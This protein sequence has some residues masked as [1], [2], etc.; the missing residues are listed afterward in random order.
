MTEIYDKR[1]AIRNA[2]FLYGRMLVTMLLNLLT[3]RLVLQNL[4]VADMAIYAVVGSV[5]S[6]V[7]FLGGSIGGAVQRFITYEL[8]KKD[9]NVNIVFNS[10]LNS[11]FIVIFLF[12]VLLETLGVWLLDTK[13]NIPTESITAAHWAFHFCVITFIVDTFCIPYDSIIV[14]HEKMNVFAGVTILK[15]LLTCV[16][17]FLISFFD[18][19]LLV[20]SL[21]LMAVSLFIRVLYQIYCRNRFSSEIK[22]QLNIDKDIIK[23]IARYFGVTSFGSVLYVSSH[24][25]IVWVLNILMGVSLNAVFNIANQLKNTIL[26]FSMNINR[27]ISPQ[28]TK[29]YANGMMHE[30][31]NLVNIGMRLNAFMMLLILFPFIFYA[32]TFMQLWLKDVPEY[33]VFF[34]QLIAFS[35]FFDCLMQSIGSAVFATG[36]I[37]AFLLVTRS[38]YLLVLPLMYFTY[39]FTLSPKSLICSVVLMDLLAMFIQMIIVVK[40]K[41][42]DLRDGIVIPMMRIGCVSI[43]SAIICASLRA[44]LPHDVIGLILLC[45]LHTITILPFM[46]IIGATSGEKAKIKQKMKSFHWIAQSNENPFHNK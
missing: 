31:K 37:K 13:L 41:I 2:A 17:A 33:T 45:L 24:Q 4:G 39:K 21:G 35:A 44:F 32:D 5:I 3:T 23:E 7:T 10:C 1:R 34:V 42:V 16:V 9:G 36:R 18:N 40:Q 22:Y 25:G 30:H 29:T 28:I 6:T 43:L 46:V 12:V 27:A 11:I 26:S 15:V 19:R 8:G 38:F 20:Y 14:A